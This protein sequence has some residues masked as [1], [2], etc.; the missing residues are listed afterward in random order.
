MVDLTTQYDNI[1]G[2]I[3]LAIDN[4]LHSGKFINGDDVNSFCDNL[5]DLTHTK[6]VIP[7]ANGTDALQV[8]LMSLNL[9]L[10]D[11]IIVPAFTYIAAVE[12]IAL[13]K[14]TPVLIDVDPL[15][16]NM[17]PDKILSAISSKTRAIIP[18][19]LFGQTC[20]ME[21]ILK[22]CNENNI[23]IIEDNA[24]SIGS[25]YIFTNGTKK[26]AGTIGDIGTLSF[27]PTKNLG[28][29]GDGGAIITDNE[30]L[31]KKIKM[32]T[33]HGQSK[34]YHH[35][36]IGCNSRLDTLQAAI[37]NVKIKYLKSFIEKRQ[38]AADFY[39]KMLKELSEYLDIPY[40]AEYSSH[41]FHQYT[42]TVKNGQRD[43]LQKF[44]Q[45]NKIPSFIYYPVPVQKQRAFRSL[46]RSGSNLNIS[47]QLSESV[48]S[49]PMHTELDE[50]QLEFIVET[51]KKFFN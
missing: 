42:I 4:V 45:E 28:C 22:L 2:E 47:K 50:E 29:Y 39:D 34:K 6:Y 13:L 24:Q 1:K 33:I 9:K 36:L 5:K 12:A 30:D 25:E 11:E 8:A 19:H 16:F 37:L 35:E 41:V 15:T 49:L 7:C 10:E 32:L 26:Q 18:V 38:K 27:F 51:I 46:I 14:L 21:P 44:L 20:K 48:L 43:A 31:A 17:D 23:Y 3:N 40:R